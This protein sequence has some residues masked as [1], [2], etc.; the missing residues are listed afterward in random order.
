MPLDKLYVKEVQVTKL[1]IS[2][3]SAFS[4]GLLPDGRHLAYDFSWYIFMNEI[5]F[6]LIQI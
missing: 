2:N 1:F 3:I 4:S 6:L 5:Y